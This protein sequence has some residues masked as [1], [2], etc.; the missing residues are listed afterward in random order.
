M[1][2]T[3]VSIKNPVFAVMVMLGLIVLG[4]IG[5]KKMAVDKFPDVELPVIVVQ[6]TYPGAAPTSVENEVSR[7][8]E[9]SL[10][11]VSGIKTMTS[12][13]YQNISVIVAQFQTGTNMAYSHSA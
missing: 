3:K 9:E 13:S 7:P 4:V 11:T 10:N 5:F 8:I 12:R 6:T 2:F 1:W